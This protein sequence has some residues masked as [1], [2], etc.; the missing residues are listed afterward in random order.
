MAN[1]MGKNQLSW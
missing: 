1:A